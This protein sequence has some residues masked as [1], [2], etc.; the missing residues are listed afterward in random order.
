MS[1]EIRRELVT[2][3]PS[4]AHNGYLEVF[5]NGGVTGLLL[6][7]LAIYGAFRGVRKLMEND[8]E[9]GRLQLILLLSV[10]VSNWTEATFGRPTELM[11]F[12]LLL[13]AVAPNVPDRLCAASVTMETPLVSGSSLAGLA[14]RGS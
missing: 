3:A 12:V 4:Q 2:F 11:W 5:L 7:A 13:V 6:L 9:Y 14:E 1:E 10:L 8:F